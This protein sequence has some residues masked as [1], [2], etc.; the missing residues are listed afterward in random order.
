[1]FCAS[2]EHTPNHIDDGPVFGSYMGIMHPDK[3]GKMEIVA[4]EIIRNE[5]GKILKEKIESIAVISSETTNYN[6]L[7]I[8]DNDNG[9]SKLFEVAITVK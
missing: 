1:M 5:K 7:I 3:K 6:T 2:L 9:V 8:S 4:L